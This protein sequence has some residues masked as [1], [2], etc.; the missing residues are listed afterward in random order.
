[1]ARMKTARRIFLL[2]ASML[3]CGTSTAANV[4]GASV[5][6]CYADDGSVVYQDYACKGGSRVDIKADAV[7][8][9]AVARLQE[10]QSAF[11]RRAAEREASEAAA[12]LRREEL[13]VRARDFDAAQRYADAASDAADTYWP[14]YGYFVPY[15]AP[16]ERD[17][18]HRAQPPSRKQARESRVPAV[19]VPLRIGK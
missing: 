3:A 2:G 11:D 1:M 18:R 10:A 4:T 15:V 19:V 8:P 14:A 17:R 12:S 6:K 7:D 16:R 13:A 9:Y 5:Y